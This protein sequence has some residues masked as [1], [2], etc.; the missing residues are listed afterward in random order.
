MSAVLLDPFWGPVVSAA[1][2]ATVMTPI[3]AFLLREDD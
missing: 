2:V 1:F 3:C